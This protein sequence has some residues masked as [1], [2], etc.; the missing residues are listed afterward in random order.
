MTHRTSAWRGARSLK[1]L[2]VEHLR[3]GGLYIIEDWA[4]G[5]SPSDW[6]TGCFPSDPGP[7]A[8]GYRTAIG[9]LN[10]VN[11]AT[12]DTVAEPP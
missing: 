10:A 5:Y 1:A 6:Q 7:D 11:V 8:A 3:P 12:L 2:F 4:T 9:T